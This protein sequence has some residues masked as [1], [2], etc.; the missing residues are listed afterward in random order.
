MVADRPRHQDLVSGPD[1]L[2]PQFDVVAHEADA[3]G[4]DVDTVGFAALHDLGVAGCDWNS[5]GG[6]RSAQRRSDPLQIR[7]SQPFLDDERRRQGKRPRAGHRQ[8]VQGSV[9]RELADVAARKE[10]RLHH[11]RV[12]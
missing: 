9:H 6:C 2:R 4:V 1:A 8:V 11:E 12:G 5:R 3:R 10:E 7:R